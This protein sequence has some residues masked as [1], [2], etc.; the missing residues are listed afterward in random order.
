[1][2]FACSVCVCFYVYTES[3]RYNAIPVEKFS[4]LVAVYHTDGDL[5][6]SEEYDVCTT[7]SSRVFLCFT[8]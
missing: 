4:D 2:S 3:E 8:Y 6:F 1:M 7:G 5:K